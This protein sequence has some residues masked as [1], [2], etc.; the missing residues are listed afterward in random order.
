M[1]LY[2]IST[3]TYSILNMHLILYSLNSLYTC[4]YIYIYT[5]LYLHDPIYIYIWYTKPG[6]WFGTC[7]FSLYWELHNP[8]W[9]S[10]F[11]FFR[12]VASPPTSYKSLQT[13]INQP[14]QWSNNGIKTRDFERCNQLAPRNTHCCEAS[15]I[16][17]SY[18]NQPESWVRSWISDCLQGLCQKNET[19]FSWF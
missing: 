18:V 5:H 19:S 2:P 16:F 13:T 6:W 8:N 9:R 4:M 1:Y 11:I 17:N 10:Y 12:G 7:F 14:L 15:A 3:N